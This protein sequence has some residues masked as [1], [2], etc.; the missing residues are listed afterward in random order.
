MA[1]IAA[2]DSTLILGVDIAQVDTYITCLT[3]GAGP[4][5]R[6]HLMHFIEKLVAEIMQSD[7]DSD[8]AESIARNLCQT[9]AETPDTTEA[10]VAEVR[11]RAGVTS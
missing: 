1:G 5:T 4:A 11:R 7:R 2:Q 10:I 8:R 6:E 9:Y 3:K